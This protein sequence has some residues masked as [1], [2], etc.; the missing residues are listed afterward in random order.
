MSSTT[1]TT[2]PVAK[3][4]P[5]GGPFGTIALYPDRIISGKESHPLTGVTAEVIATG[6]QMVGYRGLQISGP[7]FAWVKRV[8]NS[9]E[10]K[11]REFAAIITMIA[12]RV[13]DQS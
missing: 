9:R 6:G 12:R 3:F 2:A 11:A 8:A 10:N 5:K 7:D 1:T 4:S 13:N